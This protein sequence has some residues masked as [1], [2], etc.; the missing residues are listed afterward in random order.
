MN[1]NLHLI[2]VIAI[3]LGLAFNFIIYGHEPGVG[4]FAYISLLLVGLGIPYYLFGQKPT[5]SVVIISLLLLFFSGMVAVRASEIITLLNIGATAYLLLLLTSTA[6]G[7]KAAEHS[8]LSNIGL[9]FLPLTFFGNSFQA[10]ADISTHN[11]EDNSRRFAE[12]LRGVI[13]TLPI[14]LFFLVI[15]SQA[16]AIFNKYASDIV[17]NIISTES[18]I[19]F[20]L[21]VVAACLTGGALLYAFRIYGQPRDSAP[22]LEELNHPLRLGSIETFI[23][24]GTI[25][26]IFLAFI[27]IQFAYLFGV[28]PSMPLESMNYSEYTRQGFYELCIAAS[29]AFLLLFAI[30]IVKKIRT[31]FVRWLSATLILQVYVVMA[32]AFYRLWM[33]EQAYGFTEVRFYSH[34]FIL[35][36]GVIFAILLW[37]IIQDMPEQKFI[38]A[39]LILSVIS[40]ITLNLIN[41]D[42]FIAQKNLERYASTG[43]I[44]SEYIALLSEDALPALE[45]IFAS[46][47]ENLK[48]TLAEPLRKERARLLQRPQDDGWQA[49]HLARLRFKE[50]DF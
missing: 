46:S 38:F 11:D 37:K 43:K 8:V 34:A 13:I 44:D 36:L 17:T 45:R 42:A 49:Y 28:S 41:P 25:N 2:G 9:G 19:R 22:A 30:D 29:A 12:V 3:L 31:A 4:F 40:G 5:F 35:W 33:Y 48:A 39:S 47:D 6:A 7:A 24:L 20:M 14:A 1:K 23:L 15:F 26:A 50:F 32:S 27:V 10:I 18:V 21:S 16:D